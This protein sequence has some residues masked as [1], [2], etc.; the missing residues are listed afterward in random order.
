MMPTQLAFWNYA[1]AAPAAKSADSS[2]STGTVAAG[3][4]AVA[5]L[6]VVGGLA[7]RRRKAGAGDRE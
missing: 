2:M 6:G 3:V 5:V 1:K 7:V 4:G